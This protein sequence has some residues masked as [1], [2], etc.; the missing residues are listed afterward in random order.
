MA[1][2]KTAA[3]VAAKRRLL[4]TSF[5]HFVGGI[6]KGKAILLSFFILCCSVILKAENENAKIYS[7]VINANYPYKIEKNRI[8][9]LLFFKKTV[10]DTLESISIEDSVLLDTNKT[11]LGYHKSQIGDDLFNSFFE[12]PNISRNI[13]D[14]MKTEIQMSICN[15]PSGK[16]KKSY[17]NLQFFQIGYNSDF[18][19]A[20]T[21]Y[22][23]IC[24]RLCGG[25]YYSVLRRE[26]KKWII[27]NTFLT[28]KY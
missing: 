26:S 13:R 6:L 20:V 22:N 3:I 12:R 9:Y 17:G 11:Y 18:T 25:I 19:R 16:S 1:H 15:Q 23:F 10:Y 27:E 5:F 4:E 7:A 24:G 2:L 14:S 28:I 8:D 21:G